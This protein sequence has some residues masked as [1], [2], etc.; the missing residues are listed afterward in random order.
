M[1]EALITAFEVIGDPRCGRRVERKLI[2]SFRLAPAAASAAMMASGSVGT[3]VSRIT[4]PSASTAHTPVSATGTSEPTHSSEAAPP[5]RRSGPHR[6]SWFTDPKCLPRRRLAARRPAPMPH[7]AISGARARERKASQA[8][9]GSW[10]L[11]VIGASRCGRAT[12]RLA[13]RGRFAPGSRRTAGTAA[14]AGPEP[15]H[16]P[17]SRS[18]AVPDSSLRKPSARNRVVSSRD[19]IPPAGGPAASGRRAGDGR[20]SPRRS[21]EA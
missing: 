4:S 19:R 21:P 3:F 1:V 12:E 6:G 5:S 7:L 16:V 14:V 18:G 9:D 20:A 2:G 15:A 11:L 10:P 8:H 17:P 13:R